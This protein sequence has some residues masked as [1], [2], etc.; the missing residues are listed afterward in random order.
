VLFTLDY[1]NPRVLGEVESWPADILADYAHLV[2]LVLEH[3]PALKMP[4]SRSL[5]EGLFELR[6]SGREGIGRAMYCFQVGR[7]VTVVHAFIKK[8]QETPPKELRLARR[9]V[10]EILNA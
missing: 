3:G 10:K 5:G 1:Y 6:P 2:E 7:R 8:T 9:R 4:H